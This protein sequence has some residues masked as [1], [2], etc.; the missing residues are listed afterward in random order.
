[1]YDVIYGTLLLVIPFFLTCDGLIIQMF[2]W[3]FVVAVAVWFYFECIRTI[4]N[5]VCN[6]FLI[7]HV[8]WL[9]YLIINIDFDLYISHLVSFAM[10]VRRMYE[11]NF[12]PTP[13]ATILFTFL[14]GPVRFSSNKFKKNNN[15]S[16]LSENECI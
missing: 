6:D 9:M 5:F 16:I 1:M 3:W 4:I 12:S 11:Y 13:P 8:I 7:K 15:S 2:D 14:Y 10:V